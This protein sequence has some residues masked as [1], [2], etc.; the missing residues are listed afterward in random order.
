VLEHNLADVRYT[1]HQRLREPPERKP[2]LVDIEVL[3]DVGANALAELHA[4]H[5]GAD[6][7]VRA[8]PQ[9]EQLIA[10]GIAH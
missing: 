10:V 9:P 2:E 4:V 6:I 8:F 1:V 7:T 3:E 5:G